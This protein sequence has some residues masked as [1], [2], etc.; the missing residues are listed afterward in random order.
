MGL[1]DASSADFT[2]PVTELN[3]APR[4]G[5]QTF[6]NL[7]SFLPTLTPVASCVYTFNLKF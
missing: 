3:H 4:R 6:T 5:N 7:C 1:F 2:S